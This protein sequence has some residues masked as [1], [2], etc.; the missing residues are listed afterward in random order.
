MPKHLEKNHSLD[1]D[2]IVMMMPITGHLKL[3]YIK[4]LSWFDVDKCQV[5]HA[6]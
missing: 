6:V 1:M 2:H 5:C 3:S 4:I